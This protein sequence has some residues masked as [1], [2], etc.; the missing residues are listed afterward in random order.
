M[1]GN[2]D[3]R[4]ACITHFLHLLYLSF[5]SLDLT[6][7]FD[8]FSKIIFDSFWVLSWFSL[9]GLWHFDSNL[10]FAFDRKLKLDFFSLVWIWSWDSMQSWILELILLTFAFHEQK[11][12]P[13]CEPGEIPWFAERVNWSQSVAPNDEQFNCLF[14]LTAFDFSCFFL[15]MKN[16]IPERNEARR[17][18]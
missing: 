6:L 9:S 18:F 11:I 7:H 14:Q 3:L 15:Q 8:I 13:L 5:D 17:I 1:L 12:F 4:F 10:P 2:D 16:G